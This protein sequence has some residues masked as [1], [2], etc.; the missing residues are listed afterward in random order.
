MENRD[1]QS[2][3]PIRELTAPSDRVYLQD[4]SSNSNCWEN[5]QE[6]RESEESILSS[7]LPCS[8]AQVAEHLRSL[9]GVA[10]K[11]FKLKEAR[12]LVAFLGRHL[13]CT[14]KGAATSEID[15][16]GLPIDLRK[17]ISPLFS[18]LPW[19]VDRLEETWSVSL[20]LL[21][22]TSYSAFLVEGNSSFLNEHGSDRSSVVKQI[23]SAGLD[24]RVWQS[25]KWTLP[26]VTAKVTVSAFSFVSLFLSSL[27]IVNG[28]KLSFPEMGSGEFRP[29]CTYRSFV[30]YLGY[31]MHTDANL[32]SHLVASLMYDCAYEGIDFL[33][34][35]SSDRQVVDAIRSEGYH[36]AFKGVYFIHL[37]DPVV[38]RVLYGKD[39]LKIPF[40]EQVAVVKKFE[41][42]YAQSFAHRLL[43]DRL[44]RVAAILQD[45]LLIW[46]VS[47]SDQVCDFGAKPVYLQDVGK[48]D[49]LVPELRSGL[50]LPP[51][52]MSGQGRRDEV[53]YDSSGSQRSRQFTNQPD[54]M[55]SERLKAYALLYQDEPDPAKRETLCQAF[56]TGMPA[57]PPLSP[58]PEPED[59]QLPE[60]EADPVDVL[61]S[62]PSEHPLW[63]V[64]PA[65]DDSYPISLERR[66]ER[67]LPNGTFC[68]A[69]DLNQESDPGHRIEALPPVKVALL[70]TVKVRLSYP[71]SASET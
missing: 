18:Y 14:E 22:S 30:L 25:F 12:C 19:K 17:N 35:V 15:F 28:E 37:V 52:S 55:F 8:K 54:R 24:Q 31:V 51:S 11:S 5:K 4:G 69:P 56:M 20:K 62:S 53:D 49:Q 58:D 68:E 66:W 64:P 38:N 2:R 41:I 13:M 39:R 1:Y 6:E 32:I 10:K 65:L 23:G 34:I 44:A 47:R 61:E 3:S 48:H 60:L 43:A 7:G 70:G 36:K 45:K 63:V 21:Q 42:T 26:H 46:E 71:P 27:T 16:K 67:G 29:E 9:K 33:Y 57:P 59:D 40:R 50:P